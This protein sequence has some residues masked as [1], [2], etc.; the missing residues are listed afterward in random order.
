M[1]GQRLGQAL[2]GDGVAGEDRGGRWRGWPTVRRGCRRAAA[3]PSD[4]VA[5]ALESRCEPRADEP[6]DPGDE[7]VHRRVA[8]AGEKLGAIGRAKAT[9]IAAG[10]WPVAKYPAV[11]RD[12]PKCEL[13]AISGIR[14]CREGEKSALM[15]ADEVE[16]LDSEDRRD[17][18]T[19]AERR[20]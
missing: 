6:G 17:A 13:L 11:C 18:G 8:S 3:E 1:S 20:R 2:A 7:D 4:A 10:L 15:L 9:E 16:L 19:H 12:L 5:V 14:R